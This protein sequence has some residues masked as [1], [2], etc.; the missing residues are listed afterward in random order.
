MTFTRVSY[1]VGRAGL[2]SLFVLGAGNKLGSYEPTLQKMSEAGI[3]QPDLLLPAV[4]LLELIGGLIVAFG[5][6]G[7]WPSAIA[8][9]VFTLATNVMFH[10]FWMMEGVIAQ[11]E[12]SLFFKNIAIASGLVLVAGIEYSR[13]LALLGNVFSK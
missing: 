6:R 2:A 1:A 13:R 8:L 9:A 12:L 4:I 5:V 3:Q 10:R 11:L 7:S